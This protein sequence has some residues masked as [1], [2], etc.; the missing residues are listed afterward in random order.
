MLNGKS[1]KDISVE[2]VRKLGIKL[3]NDC[4]NNVYEFTEAIRKDGIIR[5]K[6]EWK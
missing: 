6:E 5:K 2:E 3:S 4:H 1:V